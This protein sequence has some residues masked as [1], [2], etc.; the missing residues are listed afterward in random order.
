MKSTSILAALLLA[1]SPLAVTAQSSEVPRHKCDPKPTLPGPRMMED[2]SVVKRFQRDIDAYKNC[3]KA[4][5]DERNVA[6]KAHVD[7][8]N[9]AIDEYNTTMKA[10]QDSQQKK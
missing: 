1:V 4:Y 3:M 9:A 6:S 2:S 7:A 5:A 10:L 8:G